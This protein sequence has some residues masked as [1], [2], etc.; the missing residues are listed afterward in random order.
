MCLPRLLFLEFHVEFCCV[1]SDQR[2]QDTTCGFM[3]D[4]CLDDILE[5]IA[6]T[7]PLLM[8]YGCTFMLKYGD[9]IIIS[10]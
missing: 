4:P 6:I 10:G 9:T 8:T 5:L 2:S 7:T 1:V 3:S